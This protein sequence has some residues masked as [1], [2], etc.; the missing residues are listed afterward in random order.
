MS[1]QPLSEEGREKDVPDTQQIL[2]DIDDLLN[3]EPDQAT[4]EE[5]LGVGQ[6]DG[7]K[8][9]QS[10]Q[11]TQTD[12]QPKDSTALRSTSL[13]DVGREG[14]EDGEP[15]VLGKD[16][17]GNLVCP[18]PAD[19]GTRAPGLQTDGPVHGQGSV[20]V[21]RDRPAPDTDSNP[22]GKCPRTDEELITEEATE[23]RVAVPVV[24]GGDTADTV[25]DSSDAIDTGN[26]TV[27][28]LTNV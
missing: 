21:K 27:D 1:D 13:P 4:L 10:P 19:D 18:A 17:D 24:E 12:P 22:G 6:A 23:P 11:V 28:S 15:E 7:A 25:Q 20:G 3:P 26:T 9:Q 14:P 16:T 2:E 5:A 8:P